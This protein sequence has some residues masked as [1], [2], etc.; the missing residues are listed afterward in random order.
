MSATLTTP[1]H[2]ITMDKGTYMMDVVEESILAFDDGIEHKLE[3]G[4]YLI[5]VHAN[6]FKKI[7]H[8]L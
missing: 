1:M 4:Q 8:S 5:C 6:E 2:T 3:P 7:E